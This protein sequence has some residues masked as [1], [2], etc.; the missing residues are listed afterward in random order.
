[1]VW[2]FQPI[3]LVL[4][5]NKYKGLK[6]NHST[7]LRKGQYEKDCRASL[8]RAHR[9]Q[10]CAYR[11]VLTPQSSVWQ[12]HSVE[13][14]CNDASSEDQFKHQTS[15]LNV[16]TLKT[17]FLTLIRRAY[18]CINVGLCTLSTVSAE[19][20]MGVLGSTQVLC[21]CSAHSEHRAICP[22]S[23][24]TSEVRTEE[25]ACHHR[26][27]GSTFT[28]LLR[29]R[30]SGTETRTPTEYSRKDAREAREQGDSG[31]HGETR[32]LQSAKGLSYHRLPWLI[33]GEKWMVTLGDAKRKIEK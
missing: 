23:A 22:A 10:P 12:W 6:K 5:P 24:G 9:A 20:K 4:T 13:R 29:E 28:L 19:D 27:Q 15:E 1:M 21:K 16:D 32:V 7:L 17:V 3:P 8:A 14:V 2:I 25:K 11:S 26:G 18:V 30:Q 33:C 31:T